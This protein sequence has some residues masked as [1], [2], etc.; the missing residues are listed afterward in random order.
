MSTALTL[1]AQSADL[2][3]SAPALAYATNDSE[4]TTAANILQGKLAQ[5]AR[6]LVQVKASDADPTLTREVED[7]FASLSDAMGSIDEA[8][9]RRLD[10]GNKRQALTKTMTD[11]HANFLFLAQPAVDQAVTLADPMSQIRGWTEIGKLLDFYTPTKINVVL[12]TAANEMRRELAELDDQKLLELAE[13]EDKNVID[14]AFY[15]VE[16]KSG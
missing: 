11:N 14:G 7:S 9:K 16:K 12:S 10:L 8:V 1:A 4:R 3:A 15:R 6:T 2:A 5:T 13:E